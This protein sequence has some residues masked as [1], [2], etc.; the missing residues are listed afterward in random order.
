M[1][2]IKTGRK[3]GIKTPEIMT[4]MFQSYKLF[5]KSNPRQKF[6][7]NQRTGDMV[8][9]PLE[10]PL[11]MEGFSIFCFNK[12]NVSISEYFKARISKEGIHEDSGYGIFSQVC[13]RIKMEIR[14][15]QIIGGMVGQYNPSI[16][17][18]LNSL[19]EHVVAVNIEQPLFP[20]GESADNLGLDPVVKA[21]LMLGDQDAKK[22]DK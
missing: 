2:K 11:T 8:A 6:H 22:E 19:H 7:L 13:S 16:T 18:R 4:E 9:E 12:Y 14:E 15:D 21:N 17:Q 3:K 10:V 5:R 20:E 1:A